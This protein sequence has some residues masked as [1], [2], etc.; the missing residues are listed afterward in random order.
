M[1]V[2]IWLAVYLVVLAALQVGLY[3]YFRGRSPAPDPT[4]QGTSNARSGYGGPSPARS[5]IP[6][7]ECGTVNDAHSSVRYCRSCVAD[8][9]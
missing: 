1:D 3:R 6:C 2:W 9:R 5:G 4:P 8:L 7:G